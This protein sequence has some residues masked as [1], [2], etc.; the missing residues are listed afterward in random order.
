MS[1]PPSPNPPN[2]WSLWFITE[3]EI[4]KG[5]WDTNASLEL[6]SVLWQYLIHHGLLPYVVKKKKNGTNIW[7]ALPKLGSSHPQS[8][9]NTVNLMKYLMRRMW[10]YQWPLLPS[11][12]E[13]TGDFEV[14][15]MSNSNSSS[16]PSWIHLSIHYTAIFFLL[17]KMVKIL[18]WWVAVWIKWASM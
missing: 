3:S 4:T 16:T 11:Y 12:P 7:M 18:C 13:F 2:G 8:C 1:F 10:L 6:C 14:R 5:G 17:C 15:C 9:P